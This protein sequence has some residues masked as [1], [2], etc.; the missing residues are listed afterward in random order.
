MRPLGENQKDWLDTVVQFGRWDRFSGYLWDTTSGTVRLCESL[1]RRGLL[2]KEGDGWT[3]T[4]AGIAM[5][6]EIGA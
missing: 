5:S 1:E 3:P 2:K 4:E 6:K